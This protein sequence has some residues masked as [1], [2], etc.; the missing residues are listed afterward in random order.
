MVMDYKQSV[1][2]ECPGRTFGDRKQPIYMHCGTPLPRWMPEYWRKP[3]D[4]I[5]ADEEKLKN[6]YTRRANLFR[7]SFKGWYGKGGMQMLAP[8]C[9]G[10]IPRTAATAAEGSYKKPLH[11]VPPKGKCC[12]GKVN[13]APV[14]V[15]QYQ[16]LPYGTHV[17]TEG[18]KTPR[19]LVEGLFSVMKAKGGFAKGTCQALGLA[20]N[21]MAAVAAAVA[22]NV[23]E[24]I[25]HAVTEDDYADDE[26]DPGQGDDESSVVEQGID[27]DDGWGDEPGR[28]PP[29]T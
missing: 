5:L 19:A 7:F 3:S 4:K 8:C 17:W 6:W 15:D 25:A 20:A 27:P 11:K 10:R 22:Y 29:P 28:A 21:T 16:K 24:A 26:G 13:A 12:G 18:Y 2:D 14:E 23:R 9:A 1:I